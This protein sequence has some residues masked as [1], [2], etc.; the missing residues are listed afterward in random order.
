M[1]P[2]GSLITLENLADTAWKPDK[3]WT[4]KA[5]ADYELPMAVFYP[6]G[7][8]PS[9]RRAAVVCIHGG[10]WRGGNA[11]PGPIMY[12][13]ARYFASRGAVAFSIEYRNLPR[14]FLQT[15]E[16][17]KTEDRPKNP[18]FETG[19]D[20]FNLLSDC[21]SALRHIRKQRHI[22]GIDPERISVIGD[23]AGGHLAA[24]LGTISGFDEP[25]EDL[26]VSG[27][28][29]AMIPCNPI[30]DL[31]VEK[32]LSF[33]HSTPRS[34]EKTSPLTHL[35]RAKLLSPLHNISTETVPCL[36]MHGKLDTVVLPR[37]STDFEKRMSDRGI[38]CDIQL[39]E[40]ATHAFI[41]VGYKASDHQI[42]TAM[43]KADQFL[44][45]MGYLEGEA[46]LSLLRSR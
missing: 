23:S 45:S 36:I 1:K 2:Y 15:E 28:A 44:V 29:N 14:P 43:T 5:G 18:D 30:T 37:H 3:V 21:K 27:M 10:A 4:Y 33:V 26:S 19:T 38:R 20:L 31:T 12:P 41:L 35:A 46:T 11:E 32:W 7:H 24:A 6:E 39:L 34:W 9:D 13:Q 8:K 42:I 25:G 22:H 40:D 16:P 17:S